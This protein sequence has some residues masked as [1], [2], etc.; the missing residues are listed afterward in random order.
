MYVQVREMYGERAVLEQIV[1]FVFLHLPTPT[2]FEK[3]LEVAESDFVLL[4]ATP[5]STNF[6][7]MIVGRQTKFSIPGFNSMSVLQS[8]ISDFLEMLI[9]E[10]NCKLQP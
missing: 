5:N 6:G 1:F 7:A 10:C 4:R 2:K 8:W 3:N 9:I